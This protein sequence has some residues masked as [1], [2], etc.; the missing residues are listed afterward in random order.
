MK[1]SSSTKRQQKSESCD[2]FDRKVQDCVRI[3]LSRH[4]MHIAS[5]PLL[6][7]NMHCIFLLWNLNR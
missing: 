1:P 7:E 5:R 6:S 4:E 3:L 2:Q